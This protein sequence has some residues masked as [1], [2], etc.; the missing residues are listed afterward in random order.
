MNYLNWLILAHVLINPMPATEMSFSSE[1][2][3]HIKITETLPRMQ[4][5][6]HQAAPWHIQENSALL[7][8]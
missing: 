7:L 3:T 2:Q 1:T 5:V 8:D 4:H 6:T